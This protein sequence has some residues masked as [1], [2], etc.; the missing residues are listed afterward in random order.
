MSVSLPHGPLVLL[1]SDIKRS[2]A[3]RK[4]RDGGSLLVAEEE[5]GEHHLQ[6]PLA[7]M[8][9]CQVQ[10]CHFPSRLTLLFVGANSPWGKAAA[11]GGCRE[12][13]VPPLSSVFRA[14][15]GTFIS[16]PST[17]PA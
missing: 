16:D 15:A 10:P 12:R 7:Q 5:L 13:P 17:H 8:G 11:R 2:F 4:G 3:R 14:L 9:L 1:R 6:G